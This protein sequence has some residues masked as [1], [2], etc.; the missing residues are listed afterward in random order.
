[1]RDRMMKLHTEIR[2]IS[3]KEINRDQIASKQDKMKALFESK[4]F[5]SEINVEIGDFVLV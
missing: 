2:E 1:M 4:K 5:P 3:A